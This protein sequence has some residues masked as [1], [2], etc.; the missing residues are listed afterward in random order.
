[1]VS[2]GCIQTRGR[3]RG[4][5]G[6][7]GTALLTGLITIGTA[8]AADGTK[9]ELIRLSEEAHADYSNRRYRAC[10]RRY[11]E[12]ATRVNSST[13]QAKSLYNAA[14]CHARSKD[15]NRA[16]A[17][18]E[19]AI[20][21]GIDDP[22]KIVDS[23][24]LVSLRNDARWSPLTKR[25]R[26]LPARNEVLRRTLVQMGKEDQ[27]EAKRSM[28]GAVGPGKH[29]ER[30]V[31]LKQ[32]LEEYGGPGVH[33]AGPDGAWGAWIVA[34]HA[35]GD[36][37]FQ[38]WCLSLLERAHAKG[39]VPGRHLAY[40]TDRVRTAEN[41]PQ[42]YGTQG[43]PVYSEAEK[44]E[45]NARRKKLGMPTMAESARETARF[46]QQDYRNAAA[47]AKAKAPAP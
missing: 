36:P 25:V 40:L 32:I 41:R 31:L 35:D 26:A 7:I 47:A 44:A 38:R 19:A 27:E 12:L 37:P 45:V 29:R 1:M 30:Q 16:F 42:V 4:L 33:L 39:E 2:A 43:S 20:A 22:G 3:A 6:L 28:A 15:R 5:A 46:Y 23:E 24:D 17:A 13:I 14:L 34:Q 8:F 21:A 9:Q 10:A 11:E 18:L